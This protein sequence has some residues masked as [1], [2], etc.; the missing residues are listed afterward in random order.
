M[1]RLALDGKEEDIPLGAGPA[2]FV[3]CDTSNI[4]VV[5]IC[6]LISNF[7]GTLVGQR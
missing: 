6:T 4:M 7:V 3:R 5:G 2:L 1:C